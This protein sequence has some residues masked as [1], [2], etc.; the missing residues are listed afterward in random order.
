MDN[1]RT[2]RPDPAACLARLREISKTFIQPGGLE[3]QVLHNVSLDIN[4]GDFIALTGG[5]GSGKSTLLYIIGLLEQASGGL[6]HLMERDVSAM[7]DDEASAARN[8]LIGFVFQSFFLIPYASALENVL[9]SG[10]YTNT[11]EKELRLRAEALLEQVGLS[12]RIHFIPARLSG[13]QQQRVAL[14]RALLN[15]PAM[16]LA[17]EPT[18]QLDTATS[19]SIMDL[20]TA[21]NADGTTIVM[22]THNPEVADRAARRITV[23]D[24]RLHTPD[25]QRSR[26]EE[27]A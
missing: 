14:A 18:G 5:S 7:N 11:P 4:E 10:T 6:Y 27:A 1:Q 16:L 24:G 21:I 13:G 15:K 2:I 22:V 17:D 9:L 26:P 3:T 20:L 23:R 12:D 19:R 25:G 8:R